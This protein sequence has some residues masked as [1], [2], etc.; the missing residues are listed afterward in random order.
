MMTEPDVTLTDYGLALE[1]A[2]LTYLLYR[3]SVTHKSLRAWFALFFASTGAAALGGGTVHGF[4]LDEASAGYAVVW[5]LTL[6]AIG[7][8]AMAGWSIGARIQFS[9]IPARWISLVAALELAGYCAIVLW[10]TQTF[11]VAVANYLP[12]AI[13][14][15]LAFI[16]AYRRAAPQQQRIGLGFWGL[17]LTFI[18]TALQQAEIGLHPRYFNH[19]ALYHLI[20]A[21]ALFLIF[22]AARALVM[23]REL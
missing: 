13:F 2:L 14:L 21:V 17:L 15:S 11:A 22:L 5:P 10:V 4:F 23:R 1:N 3:Q 18:G 19:N 12:A 9:E 6:I 7:V 16:S 8:A 20:Q